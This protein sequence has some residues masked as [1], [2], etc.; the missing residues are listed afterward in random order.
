M[1]FKWYVYVFLVIHE[2]FSKCNHD[3]VSYC[4]DPYMPLIPY[5]WLWKECVLNTCSFYNKVNYDKCYVTMKYHMETMSC[6][7]KMRVMIKC[8][9]SYIGRKTNWVA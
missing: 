4:C 5:L 9:K 7:I 3:Y 1:D 6:V 8:I 2:I